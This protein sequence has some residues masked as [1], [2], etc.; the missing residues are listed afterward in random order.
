MIVSSI[1]RWIFATFLLLL[2]PIHLSSPNA[3][4]A[5]SLD[6]LIEQAEQSI[7]SAFHVV[8][9]AEG[10]GGN[11]SSLTVRLNEAAGLLAEARILVQNGDSG[12][13][14]ELAG[15]SVE[16]A[17]DVKNKASTLKASALAHRDFL[18]K[19]SLAGSVVGVPTFLFLMFRLWH[20]FK[21]YYARRILRLRPEI[22]EDR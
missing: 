20:W 10:A 16:I 22:L 18:F 12:K 9:E 6:E 17:D 8:L 15:Y 5:S 19:V 13:A 7:S 2:I 3:V 14:A 11:V 1:N 21:G 4:S